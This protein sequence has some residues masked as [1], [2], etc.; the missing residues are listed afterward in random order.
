M[1]K[2]PVSLGFKFFVRVTSR[3]ESLASQAL[4]T[5]A[6]EAGLL[7]EMLAC[8]AETVLDPIDKASKAAQ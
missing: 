5:P 3:S 2:C 8:T 1:E 6:P 7:L 4:V